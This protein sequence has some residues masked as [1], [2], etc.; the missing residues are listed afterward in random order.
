VADPGLCEYMLAEEVNSRK[1][2][3]E[4]REHRRRRWLETIL[5]EQNLSPISSYI[6]APVPPINI[7][8]RESQCS[9]ESHLGYAICSGSV[10][11][12]EYGSVPRLSE[13]LV[14]GA[15]PMQI[16]RKRGRPRKYPLA[17]GISARPH[18]TMQLPPSIRRNLPGVFQLSAPQS[19]V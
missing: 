8:S 19:L 18:L 16:K 11:A 5:N 15:H 10:V 3:R 2:E 7:R 4:V 1:D 17:A 14:P 12:V 6:L 13:A 9:A